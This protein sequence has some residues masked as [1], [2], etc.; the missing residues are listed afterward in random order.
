M[1]IL[2]TED[3]REK[4]ISSGIASDS[5]LIGCTTEELDEIEDSYGN[6]PKSYREIMKLIGRKAGRLVDR[7]EFE[8]YLD[9]ILKINEQDLDYLK[10]AVK[11]EDIAV[12]SQS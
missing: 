3:L 12:I 1:I 9:Q 8:F 6:L 10:L 4:L 11:E 2:N 5:Q 7:R